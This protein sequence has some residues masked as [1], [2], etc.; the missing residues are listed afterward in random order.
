MGI[1]NLRTTNFCIVFVLELRPRYGITIIST[2]DLSTS[3]RRHDFNPKGIIICFH[4]DLELNA[5]RREMS[6]SLQLDQ[7]HKKIRKTQSA[8]SATS[9]AALNEK[10]NIANFR[11]FVR[12]RRSNLCSHGQWS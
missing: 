8:S 6:T 3:N 12:D 5:F 9:S 4:F 11:L 1:K 2:I 7:N 10:E